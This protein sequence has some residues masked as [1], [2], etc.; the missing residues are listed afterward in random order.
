VRLSELPDER[1]LVDVVDEGTLAVDLDDRQPFA[2]APL[3]LVVA[4]DVDRVIGDAEPVELPAGAL[5]QRAAAADV[6]DDARDRARA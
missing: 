6:E 1:G 5:A 3:E 2:V 4:G